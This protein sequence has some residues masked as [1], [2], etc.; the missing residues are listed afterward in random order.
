M[1]Q[2]KP[3]IS[4]IAG[5]ATYFY[6]MSIV[7]LNYLDPQGC[8]LIFCLVYYFPFICQ[9]SFAITSPYG[10]VFIFT[11]CISVFFFFFLLFIFL[12]HSVVASVDLHFYFWSYFCAP[13]AQPQDHHDDM[14][15][16]SI[17]ISERILEVGERQEERLSCCLVT[18]EH[19]LKRDIKKVNFRF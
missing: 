3:I 13:S 5:M 15:H 11:V 8:L 10:R 6:R 16:S 14:R 4:I 9:A 18:D 1:A 2:S 7:L 17:G 12:V 19:L